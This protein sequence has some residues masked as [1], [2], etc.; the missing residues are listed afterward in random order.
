MTRPSLDTPP[1]P[2]QKAAL[3]QVRDAAA[4]CQRLGVY[5]PL[6]HYAVLDGQGTPHQPTTREQP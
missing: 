5:G 4:L 6:I 3:K 1:T 2:E